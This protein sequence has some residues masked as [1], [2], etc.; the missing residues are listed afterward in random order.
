LADETI[1][2]VHPIYGVRSYPVDKADV[3]LGEG[4][5]PETPEERS[6]AAQAVA[7]QE[8]YGDRPLEA[9]VV[10]AVDTATFG[11]GSALYRAAGQGEEARKLVEANPIA[12]GVGVGVGAVAPVGVP[13]LAA[14]AARGVGTVVKGVAGAGRV[15]RVAGAATAGAVEG[16]IIGAGLGAGEMFRAEGPLDIEHIASGFKS[17]AVLGGAFGGGGKLIAE[18]ADVGGRVLARRLAGAGHKGV[19]NGQQLAGDIITLKNEVDALPWKELDFS[20]KLKRRSIKATKELSTHTDAPEFLA[21]KPWQAE[22][23]LEIQR[24]AFKEMLAEAPKLRQELAEAGRAGGRRWQALDKL[25]DLYRRNEQIREGVRALE[26]ATEAGKSRGLAQQLL[27]GAAFVVATKAASFLGPL[28]PIVGAKAS[29]MMS[30]IVFQ[31]GMSGAF[32]S[33]AANGTARLAKIADLIASPKVIKAAAPIGYLA[34]A[35]YAPPP[36][37]IGKPTGGAELLSEKDGVRVYRS[38]GSEIYSVPSD[39]KVTTFRERAEEIKSQVGID[40]MTGKPKVT[41]KARE[42]I[43][44]RLRGM[45]VMD[46]KLADAIETNMVTRLE[47]LA[48]KLPKRPGTIRP[49]GPDRWQPASLE[50]AS[51][52]RTAAAVDDPLGA[53]ERFAAGNATPE[54]ADALKSV[55]PEMYRELQT[56]IASRLGTLRETLPYQKRLMLSILSGQPVDPAMEPRILDVLQG[57]FTSEPGTEGGIQAPTPAPQF[58]SV[59]K[60]EPTSAQLRAV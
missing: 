11:G 37:P 33:A 29:K 12:H 58:G 43:G 21:A 10:G 13:G 19:T 46:Y 35:R 56:Q 18:A 6:E 51:F 15:G 3:L 40:L 59:S 34:S 60:P 22:K 27:E 17:G 4:W 52:E 7:A 2:L 47:Y 45:A 38:R 48:E 39:K 28:A 23:Q 20:T 50:R 16:G 44:Q 49:P 55:W 5:R 42:A 53:A 32:A 25:E 31:K 57:H 54:D 30:D 9:G 41:R 14:K 26:A 8:I 24:A 1:N 36:A